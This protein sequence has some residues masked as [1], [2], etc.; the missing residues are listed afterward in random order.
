MAEDKRAENIQ[1]QIT[2]TEFGTIRLDDEV[3]A[4]AAAIIV[5][6][7]KGVAKNFGATSEGFIEA[8]TDNVVG[9]LSKKSGAKGIR[10][11]YKQGGYNIVINIKMLFGYCIPDLANEIQ[12]RVKR[13]V[14]QMT[15]VKVS[16][17]DI[18]VQGIDFS[19]INETTEV[20]DQHA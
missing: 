10:V 3:V 2:N 15:G 11:G 13:G 19:N 9:R 8:M 4:S 16:A 6:G 20:G 5:S 14:E 12:R 7:I 18:F 1:G 17:I